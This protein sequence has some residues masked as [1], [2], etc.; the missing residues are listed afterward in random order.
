MNAAVFIRDHQW[1][2]ESFLLS[3][4]TLGTLKL[5]RHRLDNE[6]YEY[7]I[8]LESLVCSREAMYT[9]NEEREKRTRERRLQLSTLSRE[10]DDY[11]SFVAG[12]QTKHRRATYRLRKYQQQRG[13]SESDFSV[14]LRPPIDAL[15]VD[16]KLGACAPLFQQFDEL[17]WNSSQTGALGVESQSGLKSQMFS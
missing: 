8:V 1:R 16:G 3:K 7:Q 5:M 17:S 14:D 11:P 15:G 4:S 6:N 13:G 10:F 12:A 9:A 2:H